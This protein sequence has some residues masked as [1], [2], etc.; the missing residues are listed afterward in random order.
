ML[1]A[2]TMTTT[3]YCNKKNVIFFNRQ[4][5]RNLEWRNF[6]LFSITT[7]LLFFLKVAPNHARK[8]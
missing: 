7:Y 6:F 5:L 8:S 1:Q 2:I 4:E 3:N